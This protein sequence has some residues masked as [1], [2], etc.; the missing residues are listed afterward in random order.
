MD[1]NKRREDPGDSFSFST[2]VLFL[3]FSSLYSQGFNC[4][5]MCAFVSLTYIR[6]SCVF[7]G[8]G[9]PLPQTRGLGSYCAPSAKSKAVRW[10]ECQSLEAPRPT[11]PPPSSPH[12]HSPRTDQPKPFVP[13]ECGGRWRSLAPCPLCAASRSSQ[14]P[15]HTRCDDIVLIK[16][17][18]C[19]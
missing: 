14:T 4:F 3:C 15:A 13:P 6:I 8:L 11:S 19:S 12:T 10:G 7:V 2:L 1:L 5:L 9:L 18:N 17:E 16:A